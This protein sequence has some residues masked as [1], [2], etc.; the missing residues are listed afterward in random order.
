M[1]GDSIP[2]GYGLAYFVCNY[3]QAVYWPIPFNLIARVWLL[4]YH[5]MI[6]PW[7]T[8][9]ERMRL[10]E[11]ERDRL[12][13]EKTEVYRKLWAAEELIIRLQSMVE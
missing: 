13:Y 2:A 10:M 3:D 12:V 1:N 8:V 4:V 6:N 11:A 5:W 9:V 7:V